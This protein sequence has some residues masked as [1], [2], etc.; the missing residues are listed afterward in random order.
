MWHGE[1]GVFDR[2]VGFA[3]EDLFWIDVISRIL[4]VSTAIA[5]VG[6]SVF[7][8]FVLI[9]A[10]ATL[11]VETELSLRQQLTSRWKWFVHLGIGLFL[12]TGFYNFIRAI[13]LHRG[14]GLYHGLIGTKIILALLVM[15]LAS[16]LVG[17]SEKMKLF[18]EQRSTWLKVLVGLALVIVMISGYAKV[19]GVPA[20]GN[21]IDAVENTANPTAT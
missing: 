17:R 15:F 13:P 4:H 21:A 2:K 18:R 8:A 9:P 20:K 14:D 1:E 3:M 10:S 7:L 16:A 5:L 6:G 12:V 11:P 19:R